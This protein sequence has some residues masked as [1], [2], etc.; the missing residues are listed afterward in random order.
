MCEVKCFHYA[1]KT[2][3]SGFALWHLFA[4]YTCT[5]IPGNNY[6]LPSSVVCNEEIIACLYKI[7]LYCYNRSFRFKKTVPQKW[8]ETALRIWPT[9]VRYFLRNLLLESSLV[10]FLKEAS[11]CIDQER[12]CCNIV[13]M[14][15]IKVKTMRLLVTSFKMVGPC[16]GP[17]SYS[18]IL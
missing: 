15:G 14:K 3:S 7:L 13:R 18:I 17:A 16:L 8:A 12:S 5:C 6:D 10:P 4:K 11:A 9:S 1:R 2:I